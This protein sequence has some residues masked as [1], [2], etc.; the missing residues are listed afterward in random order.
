MGISGK[1]LLSVYALVTSCIVEIA[2]ASDA[3]LFNAQILLPGM[4]QS[5]D[6][7]QQQT[8]PL[9]CPQFFVL[10]LGSGILGISV[11]KDDV[12]DD[13][14]FMTGFVSAGGRITPVIRAGTSKGMIDQIIEI[15]GNA[16]SVGFAWLWCGVAF[17]QSIP[18]YSSQ[19][20]LSLQP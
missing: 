9:G 5:I 19:L 15:D 14:I 17:S 16:N 18:L 2:Y 12:A 4:T 1:I 11:K 8:L 6:I 10:I 13:T 3:G 7:R 20:R